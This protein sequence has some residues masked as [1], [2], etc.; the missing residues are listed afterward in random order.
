MSK[1][2]IGIH[3]LGNKPPQKMLETWWK[4]S[5]LE[6]LKEIGKLKRFFH[7]TLVYWAHYLHSTPLN[8]A[9]KDKKNPLYLDEFYIRAKRGVEVKKPSALRK[10]VLRYLN[11]QM[12]KILLNDDLTINYSLITDFIVHHFFS[13][14]ELYYR[15]HYP[16]QAKQ[17]CR[18]KDV[19]CSHLADVLKKYRR[20]KIL[21]IAHSMGSIIAYD[22]LTQFAPSIPIHTFVTIGSPLGLPIIQSKI[23]AEHT[24]GSPQ[25]VR[26]KTPENIVSNWY[27][28]SDL[29]DKIAMDY[30]LNDDFAEN[31]RGVRAI[32]KIVINNYEYGGSKNP[33]KSFGYLRT[34][35]MA[36]IIS[37]FLWGERYS[38]FFWVKKLLQR[39][40]RD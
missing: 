38:P 31:S 8:P 1:I 5:M 3:G 20:K 28:L 17:D 23:A 24:E 16:G 19:I 14:L 11:E 30:S 13:E 32:D 36:E 29:N 12:D 9:I 26:L 25:K 2:I 27:N 15:T 4:A 18:P 35:E 39:S 6:G 40:K 33:H 34:P 21:L 10:R 7:F 37:D 22:V